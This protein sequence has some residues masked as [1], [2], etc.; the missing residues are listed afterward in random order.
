MPRRRPDTSDILSSKM[1][2]FVALWQ[3]DAVAAARAAGYRTPE[4]AAYKLLSNPAIKTEIRRKRRIIT[5]ESARRFAGQLNFD[6]S[7]VLNLLWEIARIP[8]QETCK[9]LSN[10]VKA[11]E[12]LAAVFDNE[13]QHIARI[14]PHLN[15]RP[16]EEI[17]FW[18]RNGHFP[19][20]SSENGRVEP[21]LRGCDLVGG[22]ED[23]ER[24]RGLEV[25]FRESKNS[26]TKNT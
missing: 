24:P 17:Q 10:Q 22:V 1:L 4:T 7:H 9:T 2:K 26:G 14:L 6:R 19:D 20:S 3:G 13:L 21:A 8:P 12:V 11:A 5:Q 15:G 16:S 25:S 23:K 18:I